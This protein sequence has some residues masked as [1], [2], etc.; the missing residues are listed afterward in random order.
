M[1]TIKPHGRM[2]RL[3]KP[4]RKANHVMRRYPKHIQSV[5]LEHWEATGQTHDPR[6]LM[7]VIHHY[8]TL[9]YCGLTKHGLVSINIT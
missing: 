1:R 3:T 2:T 8:E 4:W 7:A 9:R 6:R 5:I